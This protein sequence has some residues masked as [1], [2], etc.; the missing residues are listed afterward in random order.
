MANKTTIQQSGPRRLPPGREKMETFTFT[1]YPSQRQYLEEIHIKKKMR[2]T[3]EAM[4]EII[5]EH[6][7]NS[8]E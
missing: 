7:E 6:R 3:S 1:L 2:S 4:R 8:S 5:N